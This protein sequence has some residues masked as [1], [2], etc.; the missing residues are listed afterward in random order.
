MISDRVIREEV[1]RRADFMCEF[2]GISETDSGGELTIDHFRPKSKGGDDSPGNLIYCCIRCNQYKLDYWPDNDGGMMLWNP[3]SENSDSHFFELDDGRLYPLTATGSF[4]LKR[5]RLNRPPLVAN[6][7][8]RHKNAE[9]M[10]LLKQYQ[11]LAE[12]LEQTLFRQTELMEEQQRLLKK[13]YDLLR[14]LFDK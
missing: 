4:T 13:Q 9:N 8:N 10:R 5:L 6:R 3:R 11:S 2:C 1:R 7:L 14:L 12:L